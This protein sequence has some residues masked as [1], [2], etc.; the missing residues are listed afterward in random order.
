MTPA[1]LMLRRRTEFKGVSE[2]SSALSDQLDSAW[3][4]R[5][6]P[7]TDPPPVGRVEGQ[8]TI[9]DA[10]SGGHTAAGGPSLSCLPRLGRITSSE[11]EAANGNFSRAYNADAESGAKSRR[12]HS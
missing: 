5:R 8:A 2:A 1:L 11:N 10:G 3:L 12:G 7:V 6:S 4:Y 9:T